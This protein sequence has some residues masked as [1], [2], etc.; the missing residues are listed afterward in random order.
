[1]ANDGGLKYSYFVSY[2]WT[3]G[4]LFGDRNWGF[5]FLTMERSRPIDTQEDVLLVQQE[6]K[7]GLKGVAEGADVSIV[8]WQRLESI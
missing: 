4:N 6:S 2:F 5:G 7:K 8:S 1:M 3:K